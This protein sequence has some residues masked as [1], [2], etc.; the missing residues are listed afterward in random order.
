MF[1]NLRQGFDR[2][3]WF[4]AEG[5]AV[6][7]VYH[8]GVVFRTYCLRGRNI[9]LPWHNWG[10]ERVTRHYNCNW[11]LFLF[12]VFAGTIENLLKKLVLQSVYQLKCKLI[13]AS[14]LRYPDLNKEFIFDTDTNNLAIWAV[15]TQKL[16]KGYKMLWLTLVILFQNETKRHWY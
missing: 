6:P 9:N 2:L 10:C 1:D 7:L 12:C 3:K 8:Q 14:V 5:E 13:N 11:S 16:M 4:K 15:L